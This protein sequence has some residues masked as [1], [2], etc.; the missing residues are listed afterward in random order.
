MSRLVSESH[1]GAEGAEQLFLCSCKLI[2]WSQLLGCTAAA[3]GGDGQKLHAKKKQM[4]PHPSMFGAAG[5]AAPMAACAVSAGYSSSAAGGVYGAL[6]CGYTQHH[7][8]AQSPVL[9]FLLNPGIVLTDL[10]VDVD[11]GVLSLSAED[12]QQLLTAAVGLQTAASGG[13]EVGYAGLSVFSHVYVAAYVPQERGQC[14]SARCVVQ[15][16]RS[17][18]QMAEPSNR[19]DLGLM[20]AVQEDDILA[21]VRA[22]RALLLVV[23][24]RHC[25]IVV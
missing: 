4:Q 7:P 15:G 13:S 25:R 8:S 23:D 14:S 19:R 11:T 20:R 24:I 1:R 21:L 18:E 5:F 10:A 2:S 6:E 9:S 22:V 16:A 3:A 12:L 17:A